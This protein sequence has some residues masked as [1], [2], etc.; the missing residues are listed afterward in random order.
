MNA[1]EKQWI[2]QLTH[3]NDTKSTMRISEIR[4][5]LETFSPVKFSTSMSSSC[6]QAFYRICLTSMFL[7][8]SQLGSNIII[9]ICQVGRNYRKN[10]ICPQPNIWLFFII[11]VTFQFQ[12]VIIFMR[13]VS[14]L[15]GSLYILRMR[16]FSVS[17]NQEIINNTT[18]L[19]SEMQR[20]ANN[21]VGGK[22]KLLDLKI[23]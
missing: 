5:F 18:W 7:Q 23:R 4:R 1:T 13:S 21:I 10:N 12:K 14:Y 6:K 11:I 20:W 15:K 3:A 22:K 16:E 17:Y 2:S 19:Y 8:I 9:W